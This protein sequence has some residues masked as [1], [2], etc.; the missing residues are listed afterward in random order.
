MPLMRLAAIDIGTNTILLLVADLE[1]GGTVRPVLDLQEIPRLGKGVDRD[2][3]LSPEAMERSLRVLER[4]ADE[5]RHAGA[6]RIVA[7]GTSALRDASNRGEFV[8]AVKRRTGIV[9]TILS[10]REE[11]DR[12]Y[13]G[14]VADLEPMESS[15]E[16]AVLDIGGGSTEIVFGRGH[17]PDSLHSFDIGAVRLTERYFQDQP[18]PAPQID[19]ARALV[20]SAF[21]PLK[22]RP[23]PRRVIAVAGTPV[24]LASLLLDLSHYDAAITHGKTVSRE[25]IG[26]LLTR[27]GSMDVAS[28]GKLP[29]VQPG[30]E[31]VLLAGTLILDE[32]LHLLGVEEFQVSSRGLRFGI[33]V[34]DGMRQK[35]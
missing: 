31:D 13:L 15:Q 28:I 34:M 17:R 1:P 33:A 19:E 21:A 4:Y 23:R 27:F 24:T 22:E 2:R 11:A 30:R 26:N 10:G 7:C 35:Q 32:A 16:C 18:P 12:T 14:A 25:A 8:E 6:A 5:A 3:R 9:I 29:Q 20:Q